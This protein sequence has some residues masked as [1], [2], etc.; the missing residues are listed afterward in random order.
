MGRE[1]GREVGE[2][3]GDASGDTALSVRRGMLVGWIKDKLI[4]LWLKKSWMLF[5]RVGSGQRVFVVWAANR[6]CV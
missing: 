6:R 5:D 2:P 4:W 1:V 3:E